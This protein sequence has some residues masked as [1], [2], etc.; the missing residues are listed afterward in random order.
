M[1]AVPPAIIFVNNDL[2]PNIQAHLEKQLHINQTFDGYMFDGYVA[3]NPSFKD[4]VIR[5][6]QRVLVIRPFTETQNRDIADVV[7]FI[8][9]AMASV[10]KNKFG[11]PIDTYPVEKLHW[12]QLSIF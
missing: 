2:T 3:N 12:G 4:L 5:F 1:V 11:P 7:I 8:K 9:T 10:L 6:N